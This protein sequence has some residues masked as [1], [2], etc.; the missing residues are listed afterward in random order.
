MK[1]SPPPPQT[2]KT[3]KNKKKK[4]GVMVM[5]AGCEACEGLKQFRN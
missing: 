3:K 5:D 2:K 1:A 4:R